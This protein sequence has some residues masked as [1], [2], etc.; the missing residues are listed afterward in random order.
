MVLLLPDRP[1]CEL[2]GAHI[3]FYSAD[4]GW[5]TSATTVDDSRYVVRLV[6]GDYRVHVWGPRGSDLRAFWW[7]GVTAADRSRLVGVPS[8][9]S[10]QLDIELKG[11]IKSN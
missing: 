8:K 7:P 3:D 6:P 10:Q 4:G 5:V 9:D 2:S 1:A 11:A